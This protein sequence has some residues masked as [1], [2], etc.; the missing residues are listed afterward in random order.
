M[1]SLDNPFFIVY[2]VKMDSTDLD[3]KPKHSIMD[4]MRDKI[5]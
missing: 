5:F 1:F 2:I 4:S 3:Y